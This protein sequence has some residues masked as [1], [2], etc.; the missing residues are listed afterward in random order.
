MRRSELS[1][2]LAVAMRDAV[3]A[4]VH[5]ANLLSM[6]ERVWEPI[7]GLH[8]HTKWRES[9]M[10]GGTCIVVQAH[11][12][13]HSGVAAAPATALLALAEIRTRI[14]EWEC[15]NAADFPFAD[16]PSPRAREPLCRERDVDLNE[17]AT[18]P[19]AEAVF[20]ALDGTSGPTKPV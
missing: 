3:K 20:D 8:V 19:R 13:D 1:D 9:W 18:D 5:V 7:P 6:V 15:G 16:R 17:R 2:G 11:W 12:H 14:E 10:S 4:K